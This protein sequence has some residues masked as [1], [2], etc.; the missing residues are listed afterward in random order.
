MMSVTSAMKPQCCLDMLAHNSHT[1]FS[2]MCVLSLK[3]LSKGCKRLNKTAE[4]YFSTPKTERGDRTIVISESL[5][6]LL[7]DH[8]RKQLEERLG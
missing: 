3:G 2:F 7:L 8:R 6:L 5:R 4:W 1:K